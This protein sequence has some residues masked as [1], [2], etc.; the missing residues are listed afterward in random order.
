MLAPCPPPS[1]PISFLETAGLN[2][3]ERRAWVMGN[4]EEGGCGGSYLQK[5]QPISNDEDAGSLPPPPPSPIKLLETAGLN[6]TE[7]RAW[8]M[9]NMQEGGCGGSYLQK[10]Q[11]ISNDEN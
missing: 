1:P 2:S 7:R 3:T 9:G 11:P 10:Y 8:V 5:Y 6:S 4:M